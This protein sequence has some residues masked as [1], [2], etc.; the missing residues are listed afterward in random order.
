VCRK[1]EYIG[2]EDREGGLE[3]E[4]GIM[5]NLITRG[6]RS[7]RR[8]ISLME[9]SRDSQKSSSAVM[10][11]EIVARNATEYLVKEIKNL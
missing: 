7:S 3:V 10:R 5:M 6:M 1:G 4:C 8:E 2:E 9:I 11:A